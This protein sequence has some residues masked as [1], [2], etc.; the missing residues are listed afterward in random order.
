MHIVN[1]RLQL[2]IVLTAAS[3]LCLLAGRYDNFMSFPSYS[4]VVRFPAHS[5]PSAAD[6]GWVNSSTSAAACHTSAGRC[7]HETTPARIQHIDD[8]GS[9]PQLDQQISTLSPSFLRGLQSAANPLRLQPPFNVCV[10]SWMP[11][12]RCTPGEDQA[13]FNG[14]PCCI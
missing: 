3:W 6:L 4:D 2:L 10:S 7:P 5:L 12:V 9:L 14:T 8:I 13:D 1:Q 11:M